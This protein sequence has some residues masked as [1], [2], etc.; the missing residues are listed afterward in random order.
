M[1]SGLRFMLL[2]RLF[3]EWLDAVVTDAPAQIGCSCVMCLTST[4]LYTTV[5]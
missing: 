1:N 5:A 3:Q 4:L 2:D